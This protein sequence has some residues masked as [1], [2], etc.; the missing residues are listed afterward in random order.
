MSAADTEG[1]GVT[2]PVPPGLGGLWDLRWQLAAAVE[3]VERLTAER[4]AAIMAARADG[5]P[6]AAIGDVT[7]LTRQRLDQIR[8]RHG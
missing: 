7:G 2:V 3:T 6:W 4:D 8:S 1:T 5:H